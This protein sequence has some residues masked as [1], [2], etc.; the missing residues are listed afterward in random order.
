MG[1]IC[2]VLN[3]CIADKFIETG[4]VEIEPQ[5]SATVVT[6]PPSM[7]PQPTEVEQN[8]NNDVT[9]CNWPPILLSGSTVT[10][11][12]W[13][14]DSSLLYFT[15][16]DV[17]GWN[18]YSIEHQEIISQK[19]AS[20]YPPNENIGSYE[21]FANDF[22]ITNYEQIFLSPNVNQVI[23]TERKGDALR[24]Y[25]KELNSDIEVLLGEIS[26]VIGELF[27]NDDG[28][29]LLISV[30][31]Q[32]PL[33]VSDSY[34]Y[35]VDL[36]SRKIKTEIPNKPEYQGVTLIGVTPD[37]K[38]MLFVKYY[39][40]DRSIWIRKI[41]SSEEVKTSVKA[42]PLDF[43]WLSGISFLGVGYLDNYDS[44]K[45]FTYNLLED[46]S[47][48][49]TTNS[50]DVHPGFV[51]SVLISPDQKHIAF[52]SKGGQNLYMLNCYGDG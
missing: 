6:M 46:K 35:S 11:F 4:P 17:K 31:W 32:S 25:T 47:D 44:I 34:V 12:I 14:E 13:S 49:L 37:Y 50:L 51:N 2:L 27:W 52:V 23:F 48:L 16:E 29:K 7:G 5:S 42:P 8:R 30:D 10:S 21:E 22:G 36:A 9:N 20:V 39:D 28:S 43:R 18:V 33:G 15:N 1:L 3:G 45:V 19:D 41:N 40:V 26:G 24:V 38:W